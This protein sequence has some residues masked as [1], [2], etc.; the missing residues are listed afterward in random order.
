[1]EEI[2][3]A[4]TGIWYPEDVITNDEIVISFNKHV[5]NFNELNKDSI[6]AGILNK[7]EY[8]SVE[9]IEKAS[10]IKT[11]RV[12]DK[13]NILDVNRMMP[14]LKHEDESRL[15]IHAVAGIEAAK[16]AMMQADVTSD[17][18]DAVIL[19]T[20]HNARY[21]PAVAIEIQNELGIEGYAYDML[22]GCSSTTFAI[23]N[24]YSDIAS[25][26]AETILVVNPEIS[27]PA[28]NFGKRDIH[29]I[30]GDG[31][32]ASVIKKNSSSD[33]S[34]KIIDRKLMT[35][36]SNNIRSDWSYLA[37]TASDHKTSDDLIFNQNGGS[38]FKEVCPLVAE[39]I[40]TQ[41]EKNNIKVEE[42]SKFWLHQANARMINLIVSKIIGSDDFDTNLAPL[43]IET[44]GNLAS[45]GSMFAFNLNNDLKSGEK[46]IICSFGAGYSVC[47]IIV[48]KI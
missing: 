47:S 28:V 1:M 23:N 17:D 36:F 8:S 35:Q 7:L 15:S 37:R 45:A 19:G 46:G 34:F 38:V 24:A 16:K 44:F 13:K 40:S 10:G 3:I 27:T 43:P 32:V 42:I 33:K 29:F 5:D 41:L 22:V 4:G 6:S 21:Y 9:F 39:F 30:F 2:H 12:V 18:I 11:R 26:L 25:G 48:E 31:C 14:S 20:S